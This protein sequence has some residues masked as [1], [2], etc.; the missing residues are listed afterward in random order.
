[1]RP[2]MQNFIPWV[3]KISRQSMLD[4]NTGPSSV[5]NCGLTFVFDIQ[6][7]NWYIATKIRALS[8]SMSIEL[9][10]KG[11]KSAPKSTLRHCCP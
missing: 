5:A 9:D 1:M 11:L 10:S 2:W 7:P 3:W 6:H 4:T 8:V